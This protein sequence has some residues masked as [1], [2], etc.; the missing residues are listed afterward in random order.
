MHDSRFVH[1]GWFSRFFVGESRLSECPR[2]QHEQSRKAKKHNRATLTRACTFGSH[3]ID[4]RANHT[5]KKTVS[6]SPWSLT[7]KRQFPG[8]AVSGFAI[9]VSQR[10]SGTR[11]RIGS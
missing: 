9:S 8:R 4:G 1:V 6:C 2:K 7:S 5:S 10:S 11:A 3:A